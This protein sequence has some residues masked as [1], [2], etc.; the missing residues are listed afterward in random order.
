MSLKFPESTEFSLIIDRF[1]KKYKNEIIDIILFGSSIKGKEKPK[2]IDILLLFKDKENLN[3]EYELRKNIER[4]KYAVQI[5][6]KTYE[7]LFDKNFKARESFL[8]EGYSLVN[9]RFIAE[10]LGYYGCILF[11]Y[12]LKG[13]SQSKRMQFQYA[14]Y[15]R[16]KKTGIAKELALNK[17]STAIFLCQIT[18]SE[19]LKEFF[20][21]WGI[22]FEMFPLLIPG[23]IFLGGQS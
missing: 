22:K 4:L 13:F 21:R 2:D 14:L 8:G 10:G 5:T 11:K 9:K 17:F 3:I 23:R 16:D 20:E 12:S 7:K 1:Y 19:K 18:N 15:G 6:T